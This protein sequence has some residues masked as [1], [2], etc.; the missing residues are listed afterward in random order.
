MLSHKSSP[1]AHYGWWLVGIGVVILTLAGTQL[2]GS[3]V[4]LLYSGDHVGTRA[5]LVRE[6]AFSERVS[7]ALLP[8][9]GLAVDRFGPRSMLLAGLSLCA[10]AAIAASMIPVEGVAL[11]LLPVLI[12][13]RVMGTS[14]PV[15]A[16]INHWFHDRRALAIAVVLFAVSALNLLPLPV[17]WGE[18][19]NTL[20]LGTVILAVGLPL[21]AQ[22]HLPNDMA[23]THGN[24]DESAVGGDKLWDD[25]HPTVEYGWVEAVR[26]REFWLLTVAAACLAAADQLTLTLIFSVA[27]YRFQLEGSYLT[28]ENQHR[29]ASVLF[30]LVGGLVGTRVR[31]R[32]ALLA[33]SLLHVIAVVLITF[34]P[35]AWWLFAGML[36][37][38]AGSGG[39]VALG[40]AAVGEYFGRR[41]FATL[42][43]THWLIVRMMAAPSAFG[44]L[45]FS[46]LWVDP[47]W[48]LA[49]A[50]FPALAGVLAYR[51]LGDPKPA[52]SQTPQIE[53]AQ[54]G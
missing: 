11:A 50:V 23:G 10:A 13:G 7:L 28:L 52:P 26:S 18:R 29:I 51:M 2:V 33:F 22:V 5:W 32:T 42:R 49:L 3:F 4:S 38:G 46:D 53:G 34:A 39:G 44:L 36:V 47:T 15:M 1:G 8:L 25:G 45:L 43:A 37:L 30:I 17:F 48:T 31:L 9:A 12:A 41:R 40:I 6:I 19:A 27:D 24:A 35:S 54:V 20:A 14:T 21:A 16:A